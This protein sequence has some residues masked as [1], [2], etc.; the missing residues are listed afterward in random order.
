MI[1]LSQEKKDYLH[2]HFIV[3]IWGFTAVL[4]LLMT[5]PP[6]EIVFF[7]T[8]ISA[9]AL[10]VFLKL[11]RKTFSL[12]GFSSYLIVLGVGVLIAIH[13]IT[14]FLAARISNASVCL[15][16][17]ATCS[18]WTS[19]LEPLVERRKVRGFEVVLSLVAL[20]GICVIFSVEVDVV[21]GL[22]V[23]IFSAFVAS[24]F[25]VINANLTKKYNGY[26]MTFYEMTGACLSILLFL[27]IYQSYLNTHFVWKVAPMD[28]LYL[29]IL[30]LVCTVYAYSASV[31]LMKRLS[32]FSV[33]LVVNLEPVYGIVLAVIIFGD[34]E[35]MSSG[36]YGGTALILAS[37]LLYPLLNR[38]IGKKALSSS[39]MH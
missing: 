39:A 21:S 3:L 1:P 22:L 10:L 7:R 37:V 5:L 4:G 20:V 23:A 31:E 15:A 9:V 34:K 38:T 35:E 26:V 36:F 27:P 12:S 24:V 32:A 33:N 2:L 11:K 16:G 6:V 25:T 29:A 28:G 17:M 8:L 18:L 30:A 19:I 14:F 13:W